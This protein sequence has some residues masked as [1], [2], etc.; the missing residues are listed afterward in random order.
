M[1]VIQSQIEQRQ[2]KYDRTAHAASEY[3][4]RYDVSRTFIAT[5]AA[6]IASQISTIINALALAFRA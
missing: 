2:Y 4:P 5:K 3:D 6:S 1:R